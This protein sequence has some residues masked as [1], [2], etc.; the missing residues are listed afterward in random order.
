MHRDRLSAGRRGMTEKHL[1]PEITRI[2]ITYT[3][4]SS[5]YLEGKDAVKWKHIVDSDAVFNHVHGRKCPALNWQERIGRK[6]K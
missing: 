1:K 5:I 3:D 6:R 2:E 4:G